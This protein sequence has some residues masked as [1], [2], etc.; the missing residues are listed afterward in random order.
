MLDGT[1]EWMAKHGD[2]LVSGSDASEILGVKHGT[3]HVWTHRGKIAVDSYAR[4]SFGQQGA[5]YRL[6]DV[7][8]L[9]DVIQKRGRKHR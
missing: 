9:H 1:D 2:V 6:I 5:M 8:D 4:D 7:L 3:L